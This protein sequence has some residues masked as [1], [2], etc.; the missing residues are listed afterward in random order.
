MTFTC[1]RARAPT[2]KKT[3]ERAREK[4]ATKNYKQWKLIANLCAHNSHCV[5]MCLYILLNCWAQ[6]NFSMVLKFSIFIWYSSRMVELFV[7]LDSQIKRSS[8]K[9]YHLN[10]FWKWKT[11]E[12]DIISNFAV[13]PINLHNISWAKKKTWQFHSEREIKRQLF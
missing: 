1:S 9:L 7:N 10:P 11:L 5:C 3:T 13:N 2:E 4:L 6:Q 12:I 8:N